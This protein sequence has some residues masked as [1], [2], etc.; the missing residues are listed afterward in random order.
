MRP[1]L[2][3]VLL[4]SYATSARCADPARALA[5]QPTWL[6]SD[7]IVRAD[8]VLR[9]KHPRPTRPTPVFALRSSIRSSSRSFV[10]VISDEDAGYAYL[11]SG[12]HA[13]PEL[14]SG[15]LLPPDAPDDAIIIPPSSLK[16]K[17]VPLDGAADDAEKKAEKK[18]DEIKPADSQSSFAWIAGTGN[19]LGMLEWIGRD[20]TVMDY[21]VA[22]RARFS[23]DS[24][25]AARWLNGPDTT[26]LPPYLFSIFIDVGVGFKVSENW[27]FS[28]VISPSWNTDFANKSYQLFR[29]PWQAVNTFNVGPELKVVLGVTDLDREDIQ[30]LPVAGWIYSPTD[31]S[32]EY[33]MVFPRPKAAWR[34]TGDATSSNWFFV[35]GEL[36]GGS[37][38]IQRTGSVHDIVTLRD[39]RLMAGWETRGT[40]RHACRIEAGW[41]FNR[42]VE[43]ASGIGNFYPGDTAIIRIASDY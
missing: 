19:Q 29:L 28:T 34:L 23:I 31:G 32:A 9:A 27:S 13:E 35:S 11:G 1:C 17:P 10:R 8:S 40:K 20:L 5:L 15:E 12:A 26:D 21:N 18:E 33:T 22:D 43:Y 36:G 14:D 7:P 6:S 25:M 4:L 38:S 16:Q 41:V 30:F 3:I 24:G 2:L 39:Y 42:A 37:F